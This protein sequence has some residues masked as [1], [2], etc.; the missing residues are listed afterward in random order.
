MSN[1]FCALAG[2]LSDCTNIYVI[3]LETAVLWGGDITCVPL[4]MYYYTFFTTISTTFL[5]I[6]G[7]NSGR[8]NR[9]I[10]SSS[11]L[12]DSSSGY[13]QFSTSR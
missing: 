12:R 3:V 9:K 1:N 10:G 11:K 4:S 13:K 5:F 2:V 8:Y 6:S 7:K